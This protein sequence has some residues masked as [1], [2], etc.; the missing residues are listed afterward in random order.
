MARRN[1]GWNI[2]YHVL[3]LVL[4][5]VMIYPVLWMV[6]SSF[7]EHA[8]IF[9][10]MGTLIPPKFTIETTRKMEGSGRN[11]QHF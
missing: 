2:I 4:G 6:S 7:K 1:R 10:S 8:D 9:A 3:M 11:L 5:I